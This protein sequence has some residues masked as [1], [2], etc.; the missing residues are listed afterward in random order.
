MKKR[1]EDKRIVDENEEDL[2]IALPH[3]RPFPFPSGISDLQFGR[4]ISFTEFIFSHQSLLT[5]GTLS[6][7][8][9]VQSG[10]LRQLV[11][12]LCLPE[13]AE[14]EAEEPFLSEDEEEAALS[15][16][17]GGLPKAS[18]NGLRKLSLDRVLSAVAE[19]HMSAAAYRCLAR[20]MSALLRIVLMDTQ[21]S[22]SFAN[23]PP[24]HTAMFREH[25]KFSRYGY[26]NSSAAIY[27]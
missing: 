27:T 15:A 26:P 14:E 4:I 2:S 1:D 24:S 3:A 8:E 17:A 6:A 13:E 20:P 23:K 22:V 5:D 7:G 11:N 12:D 21:M 16:T 18:I 10:R 25:L 9:A 19:D